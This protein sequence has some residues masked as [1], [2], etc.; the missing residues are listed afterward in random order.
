MLLPHSQLRKL[1]HRRHCVPL[2][3]ALLAAA[4][5]TAPAVAQSQPE[6]MDF[7]QADSLAAQ[8]K[9]AVPVR[10]APLQRVEEKMLDLDLDDGSRPASFLERLGFASILT[11]VGAGTGYLWWHDCNDPE[12]DFM[13]SCLVAPRRLETSVRFGAY[14]GL[15]LGLASLLGD[16]KVRVM[17]SRFRAADPHLLIGHRALSGFRVGVNFRF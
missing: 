1:M 10:V 4:L 7:P 6:L 5:T 17:H 16:L 9:A 15:A 3:V 14:S 2:A 8:M 13:W 11:G 12:S